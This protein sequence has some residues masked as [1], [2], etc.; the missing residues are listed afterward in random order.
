[1]SRQITT[2]ARMK[3]KLVM[4]LGFPLST[5]IGT[6]QIHTSSL[7]FK[8]F[9][10]LHVPNICKNL[11]SVQ[12]FKQDTNT[13]FEFHPFYFLLKD[14]ATGKLLHQ[15]LSNHGLYS[16][17]FSA[18]NN[19]HPPSAFMGE[20]ASMSAWHSRLGHPALK[21]VRQVFSSFQL[22][23]S[24]NKS[25]SPCSTCLGSKSTQ[26]PFPTSTT[27]VTAPLHL[28]FSDV[29]GPAPVYSRNGFRYCVSFLDA[30]S[31]YT[32][33]YPISCKSDVLPVFKKFQ[34]Y[35]ERYFESKIKT[36]QSGVK[37]TQIQE[38]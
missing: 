27:R 31:R 9:D 15:G 26:L 19:S 13:F 16:F 21:V 4:G 38:I 33:V 28:I 18:S 34:I 6:S 1:M 7:A 25:Y 8:L 14:C 32:W 35:V 17:F 12:K 29:W 24:T 23:V 20:R 5:C 36:V 3:L 11:I 22:L 10:V 2:Q 30:F 37:L